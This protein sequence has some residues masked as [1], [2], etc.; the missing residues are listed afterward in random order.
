MERRIPVSVRWSSRVRGEDMK[1]GAD[2]GAGHQVTARFQ[3]STGHNGEP[4]T[5][6]R[7]RYTDLL[8]DSIVLEDLMST[9]KP[10]GCSD[11][12]RLLSVCG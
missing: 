1:A 10:L 3:A 5:R 6:G 8:V 11:T 4:G 2:G 9:L 12:S 7:K